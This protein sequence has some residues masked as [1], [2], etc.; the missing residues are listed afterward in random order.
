MP[1]QHLTYL[2]ICLYFVHNAELERLWR[3]LAGSHQLHRVVVQSFEHHDDVDWGERCW[4]SKWMDALDNMPRRGEYCF[5]CNEL[6]ARAKKVFRK[7]RKQGW[8]V[9]A[10]AEGRVL[11]K[12]PPGADSGVPC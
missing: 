4:R 3:C 5:H 11:F 12:F 7:L 6:P 2:E 9:D 1:L 8:L 10:V